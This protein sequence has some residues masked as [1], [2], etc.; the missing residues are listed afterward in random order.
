[1]GLGGWGG[2]QDDCRLFFHLPSV[3]PSSSSSPE[4]HAARHARRVR[5]STRGGG[6][7]PTGRRRQPNPIHSVVRWLKSSPDDRPPTDRRGG[8][9]QCRAVLSQT[10]TR[11]L[12]RRMEKRPTCRSQHVQRQSSS[13]RVADDRAD[14]R[15]IVVFV[16]VDP[17]SP[18]AATEGRNP[19]RGITEMGDGWTIK[20][21][22]IIILYSII[23][24]MITDPLLIENPA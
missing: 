22:T 2:C 19:R 7:W 3:R 4:R 5:P 15:S 14:P 8:T 23:L 16:S 24:L 1:V 9:L 17:R 12:G 21:D 10:K 13:R 20:E 18:P 6:G 11:T